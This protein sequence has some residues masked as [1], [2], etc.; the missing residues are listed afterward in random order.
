MDLS[1]LTER[2]AGNN[3]IALDLGTGDGRFARR[4]ARSV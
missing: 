4:L 2:L 3:R 1:E